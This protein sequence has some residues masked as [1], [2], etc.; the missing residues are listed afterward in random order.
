MMYDGF[1]YRAIAR[2]RCLPEG[3]MAIKK[4]TA[5]FARS[6]KAEPG[7]ERTFYWD[8]DMSG[9]G[10]MVM[11]AGHKSYV[12]QYRAGGM[13]RRYTIGN[14]SKIDLDVARKRAKKIFGE[15]AHD[16]DPQL[17]KRR[18]NEA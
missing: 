3:P 10:L 12:V 13:T 2:A 1:G 17:E 4:L 11:P 8:K 14:A 9:F 6:A 15:V 7:A 18:V 16:R 5:A